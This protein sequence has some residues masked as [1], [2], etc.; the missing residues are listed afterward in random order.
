MIKKSVDEKRPVPE[1]EHEDLKAILHQ[2]Q[3]QND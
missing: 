3:N 1:A 2:I